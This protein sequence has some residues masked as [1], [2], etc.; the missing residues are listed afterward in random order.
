VHAIGV[1]LPNLRKEI[2]HPGNTCITVIS[3]TKKTR[4]ILNTMVMRY[5][6][7]IV[8]QNKNQNNITIRCATPSMEVFQEEF[9]RGCYQCSSSIVQNNFHPT[10][11]ETA[12]VTQYM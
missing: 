8:W 11:A 4:G 7:G 2:R 12:G 5:V 6:N 3:Q 1:F 10:I 9:L